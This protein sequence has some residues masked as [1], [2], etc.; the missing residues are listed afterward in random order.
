[1]FCKKISFRNCV[2]RF[3]QISF[4][5]FDFFG[6]GGLVDQKRLARCPGGDNPILIEYPSG[7]VPVTVMSSGGLLSCQRYHV[8]GVLLGENIN[9]FKMRAGDLGNQF[10]IAG[11]IDIYTCIFFLLQ[12]RFP[13]RKNNYK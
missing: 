10:P 6:S 5:D 1:M 4:R 13:K 7:C 9:L 2:S 11:F 3:P 12:K 8:G